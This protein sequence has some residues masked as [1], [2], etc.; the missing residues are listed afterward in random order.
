MSEQ[1][2]KVRIRENKW[3][4]HVKELLKEIGEKS[5]F[6]VS[7][8]ETEMYFPVKYKLFGGD[9][10]EKH[11]LTY[12]PDVVWKKGMQY[13]V[14]FEIEYLNPKSQFLDKR[15]YVLGT[16][17]LGLTALHE[18]S[19]K[20]FILIANKEILCEDVGT[21]YEILNRKKIFSEDFLKSTNVLWYCFDR[22]I[23]ERFK[24]PTYLKRELKAYLSEDFKL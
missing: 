18:K 22:S 6:N 16:F 14:I 2:L 10:A 4:Q 3:H 11:I 1:G 17:L 8:S 24:E 21:C 12:K 9:S 19:C 13:Y 7:E 5:G 15:K 20:N 23:N